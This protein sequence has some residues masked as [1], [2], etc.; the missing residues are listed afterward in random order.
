MATL[1]GL[2]YPVQ[3]FH[4]H[5]AAALAYKLVP[6]QIASPFCMNN[7]MENEERFIILIN[8]DETAKRST[9]WRRTGA[10]ASSKN[11]SGSGNYQ[12]PLRTKFFA[13]RVLNSTSRRLR[14]SKQPLPV[15]FAD[16]SRRTEAPTSLSLVQLS[17]LVRLLQSRW[18]G[19]TR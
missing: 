7:E 2:F 4:F 11:G 12:T 1:P 16:T 14:M 13:S 19:R 3:A 8:N 17:L 5:V 15:S 6:S 9:F 18:I 10:S